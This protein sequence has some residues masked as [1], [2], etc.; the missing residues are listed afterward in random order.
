[1]MKD[2]VTRGPVPERCT[3]CEERDAA[4]T[5]ALRPVCVPCGRQIAVEILTEAGR[6]A[7]DIT[8]TVSDAEPTPILRPVLVSPEHHRCR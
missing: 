3:R 6:P 4:F 7:P 2:F 1:M 8:I 5:V